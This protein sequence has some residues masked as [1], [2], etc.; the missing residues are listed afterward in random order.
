MS[1]LLCTYDH[2]YTIK[3]VRLCVLPIWCVN[4]NMCQ[5]IVFVYT[6]HLYVYL[7]V[8]IFTFLHC[9]HLWLCIYVSL[10]SMCQSG[11]HISLHGRGEHYLRNILCNTPSFQMQHPFFLLQMSHF[12]GTA[13]PNWSV[14]VTLS[15]TCF[16]DPDSRYNAK[17]PSKALIQEWKYEVYIN[18][19]E[20]LQNLAKKMANQAGR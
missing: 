6:C 18:S 2:A 3:V 5:S 14:S 13:K 15:L 20:T 4:V 16:F 11:H 19:G 8:R 9:N 7:C 17:H 1:S 10:H 12:I